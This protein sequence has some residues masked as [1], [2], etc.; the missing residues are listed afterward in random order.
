MLWLHVIS[1]AGTPRLSLVSSQDDRVSTLFCNELFWASSGNHEIILQLRPPKSLMEWRILFACFHEL[2]ALLRWFLHP[3][4]TSDWMNILGGTQ[5]VSN[6]GVWERDPSSQVQAFLLLCDLEW[7]GYTIIYCKNSDNTWI[8]FVASFPNVIDPIPVREFMASISL[9][10]VI[11][12]FR[13]NNFQWIC[14]ICFSVSM[15]FM[16]YQFTDNFRDL[17]FPRVSVTEFGGNDVFP[18]S[19]KNRNVTVWHF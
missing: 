2:L 14:S 12:S 1:F 18:L 5:T 7:L 3:I 13:S 4:W 6:R 10:N 8:W 19:F 16:S 11:M 9:R 17:G 15:I